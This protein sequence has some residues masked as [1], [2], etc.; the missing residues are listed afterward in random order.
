MQWMV[1]SS[2]SLPTTAWAMLTMGA[3]PVPQA[4]IAM[5]LNWEGEQSY[6]ITA[7]LENCH[8]NGRPFSDWSINSEDITDNWG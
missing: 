1:V 6:K 3:M 8:H 7:S 4:S 2:S 5:C